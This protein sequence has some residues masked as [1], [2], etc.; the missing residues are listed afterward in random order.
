MLTI[1]GK[2]RFDQRTIDSPNLCDRFGRDDLDRIGAWTEENF[3]RDK[4]TRIAWEKRT[5]N[6]IN[7]AMQLQKEKTFPWPSCSN[8]A[9]PLVTIAALQFHARAYPAIVNGRSVVQCRVIGPDPTGAVGSRAKN[10]GEHMSWQLLEEDESWEEDTDRGLLNVS[11]VGVGWKKSYYNAS[12]GHNTSEF[13]SAKDLVVSYW[14]KSIETA[15]TKTHILPMYK[16]DIHERVMRGAYRDCTKEA[17]FEGAPA[18]K[19][20]QRSP[21]QDQ[22][23]GQSAPIPDDE[24]PFTVL[25]QHCWLDLDKDGYDEPYIITYEESST[26]VLRIVA[27]VN[28]IEDIEYNKDRRIVKIKATEYFTKIPFIP[29]PDGG[30]MDIGFGVLL[31]PLNESVNTAINQLFD[32]GTVNNTAGGFLGRGAKIRGGVYEFKPFGWHRVDATGDDLRKSVFPLPV[33]EPS[34]VMFNLLTL[35][36]D[37]TSRVGAATDMMVGENPGQNTP[38]ETSRAMLEQGQKIYSAIFKRI[39]RSMKLEFKKLYRL[40]AVHIGINEYFGEGGKISREDY[41][42][43]STSVCPVA[44]P[45][46]TTEGARYARATMLADRAA[47]NPGYNTDAVERKLLEAMGI[48]EIDTLYPGTEGQE[49]PPDVKVQVQQMKNEMEQMKLEQAKMQFML[50][51]QETV[52]LNTAKIQ[53]LMSKAASMEASA[54]NAQAKLNVEAFRAGIEA[55]REQTD[56]QN[57]Q[58]D[59]MMESMKNEQIRSEHTVPVI[60]AGAGGA[61]SGMEGGPPNPTALPMGQE[62]AGAPA[63]GMG[64]GGIFSSV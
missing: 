27:R 6:A 28:R 32:S 51:M 20:T 26:F 52:R 47:Q 25:E 35:L 18:N 2:I 31:G 64:G 60:G 30:I 21:E 29:S 42:M 62:G 9:F 14:A 61:I 24:A 7:L 36:I 46:I 59:R 40:N 17:W 5:E 22:R 49:Q 56:A 57:A 4:S 23:A 12:V 44:D 1:T 11:L 38:A 43:G 3:I 13:V 15:A 19:G 39:W 58:L 16:N 8:I 55:I 41:A 45:T 37:Y 50:T 10:I 34:A 63:G 54:N 53:E 48:D 33:R